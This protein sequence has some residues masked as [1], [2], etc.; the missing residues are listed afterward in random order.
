MKHPGQVAAIAVDV[1]TEWPSDDY[2]PWLRDLC[3][4]IGALLV[5]DEIVTGFRLARGGLGEYSGVTPD[6]AVFAKGIANGMPL[7]ALR[8]R[9]GDARVE[10]ALVSITYAARRSRWRPPG[11]L[12][13]IATSRW[14][15]RS[16]RGEAAPG[17]LEAPRGDRPAFAAVGFDPMT[18]M[19]FEASTRAGAGRVGYLLQEWRS[20]PYCCGRRAQL[21]STSQPKPT[22]M[23]WSPP[24][25]L[26]AAPRRDRGRRGAVAAMSCG[27]DGRH[28]FP[29]WREARV[30]VD[31]TCI[32]M[33][34]L[35]ARGRERC[36]ALADRAGSTALYCTLSLASVDRPGQI[37]RSNDLGWRWRP[38]PRRFWA[39]SINGDVEGF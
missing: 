2:F 32:R 30:I 10:G 9:G 5:F 22:S 35:P 17:G 37:R 26:F 7:A 16:T 15:R 6:L 28:R 13:P 23:P 24:P 31:C 1:S 19:R 39:F 38:P 14:S 21:S 33:K 20:A 27:S 12:R 29:R 11:A 3:D 25:Q 8:P 36:L 18:A 34:T 4:E